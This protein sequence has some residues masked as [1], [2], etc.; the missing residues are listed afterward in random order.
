MPPTGAVSALDV[1]TTK[2]MHSGVLKTLE[3]GGKKRQG[4]C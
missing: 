3:C 4:S 2:E 1:G